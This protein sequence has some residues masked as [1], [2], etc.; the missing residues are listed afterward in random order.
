[1]ESSKIEP[2][3]WVLR[4]FLGAQRSSPDA[5]PF[6]GLVGRA[7][8]PRRGKR[9]F[10]PHGNSKSLSRVPSEI[11]NRMALMLSLVT[12]RRRIYALIATASIGVACRGGE[13]GDPSGDG[14]G[15]PSGKPGSSG[16]GSGGG[17]GPGGSSGPFIA[18]DS[19][20]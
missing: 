19:E 7:P 8:T 17:A 1:M 15:N 10:A 13:I 5:D 16:S 2:I 11:P 12:M 4:V 20:A 18:S 14:T 3:S 9:R 6:G